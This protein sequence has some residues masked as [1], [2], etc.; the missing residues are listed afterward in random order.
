MNNY[1]CFSSHTPR[2]AELCAAVAHY[3]CAVYTLFGVVMEIYG[4]IEVHFA[5]LAVMIRG[6]IQYIVM[7]SVVVQPGH[8]RLQG[9]GGHMSPLAPAWRRHCLLGSCAVSRSI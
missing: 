6:R 3:A 8:D 7:N 5:A 4:P 1:V 2:A 9:V